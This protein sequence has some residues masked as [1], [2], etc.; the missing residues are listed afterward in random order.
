MYALYIALLGS[1][2]SVNS[3]M[4]SSTR[5]V[6]WNSGM[7]SLSLWTS[8][9]PTFSTLALRTRNVKWLVSMATGIPTAEKL[10]FCWGEKSTTCRSVVSES[11]VERNVSHRKS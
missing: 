2:V 3:L 9:Q 10:K 11:M 7:A 1:T 6:R 4:P 5:S 8:P